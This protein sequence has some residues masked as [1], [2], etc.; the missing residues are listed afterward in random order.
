VKG[1]IEEEV[2]SVGDRVVSRAVNVA[3]ALGLLLLSGCQFLPPELRTLKSP[4][5]LTPFKH[6]VT[7]Q[8]ARGMGPA[9]FKID[10]AKAGSAEAQLT[11]SNPDTS[12]IRVVWAEGTFITAES[13]SYAIGVKTDRDGLSTQPTIIEANSTIQMTVVAIG[14]DGKSVA[15]E[16]KSIE[17]P[18]RIG[19]KFTAERGL[20]R[21]KGTV[22]VF[23]L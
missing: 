3:G 8:P 4:I 14:K 6:E 12:A 7:V 1:R 15:A 17:A 19:L 10:R 5:R 23:V 22:W 13:I 21:W 20:T 9:P 11:V 18:Y 16:S 2:E